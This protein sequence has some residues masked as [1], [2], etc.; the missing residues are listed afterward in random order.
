[1]INNSVTDDG[2]TPEGK[3]NSGL[4]ALVRVKSLDYLGHRGADGF[5]TPH[6][7][8]HD[9]DSHDRKRAKDAQ[10]RVKPIGRISESASRPE[11]R[12]RSLAWTDSGSRLR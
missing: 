5:L 10:R 1:M 6:H 11:A 9:K 12:P 8:P 7:S 2:G 3:D 4:L